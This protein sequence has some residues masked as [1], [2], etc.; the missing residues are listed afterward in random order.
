[1]EIFLCCTLF[2][3]WPSDHTLLL[4]TVMLSHIHISLMFSHYRSYIY[5]Y[6]LWNVLTVLLTVI[7]SHIH[8]S[9]MFCHYISC[10]Y[11][12]RLLNVLTLLLTNIVP[13]SYFR[14]VLS[15]H[16]LY[17]Q[18]HTLKH[19]WTMSI[20]S[21]HITFSWT[22]HNIQ[23]TLYNKAPLCESLESIPMKLADINLL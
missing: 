21:T 7:L 16:I 5:S 8:I 1:M 19:I 3:T 10:I 15:L 17:I 20:T 23:G 2:C 22:V 11:S 14:N 13:Y 4:S 9:L 6:R 18:L 12:Y